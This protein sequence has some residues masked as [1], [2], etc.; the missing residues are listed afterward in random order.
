MQGKLKEK[1]FQFKIDSIHVVG[2]FILRSIAKPKTNVD[3]CITMPK[4]MFQ[5][6]FEKTY[7]QKRASF[8][9]HLSEL[10]KSTEMFSNF[11]IVPFRG[12]HLKPIIVIQPQK[13]SKS[14]SKFTK[15]DFKI[16]IL[17]MLPKEVIKKNLNDSILED[18]YFKDHLV[19]IHEYMKDYPSFVEASILLKV[20]L[21]QRFMNEGYNTINGFLL[22]YLMAYLLKTRILNKHMSSFQMIR[23]TFYWISNLDITKGLFFNEPKPTDGK[24]MFLDKNEFNVFHRITPNSWKEFQME[25][26][27]S[28]NHLEEEKK[29]NSIDYLFILKQNFYQKYDLHFQLDLKNC[30]FQNKAN[31]CEKITLYNRI[32]EI[33]SEALKDRS[34]AVGIKYPIQDKVIV[35]IKLTSNWRNAVI[36]GPSPVEKEKKQEFEN[37]WGD[38]TQMRRFK[39]S[40]ILLTTVWEYHQQNPVKMIH[41]IVSYILNKHLNIDTKLIGEDFHNLLHIPAE[42]REEY[43]KLLEQAI[44]KIKK[45]LFEVN[46]NLKIKEVLPVSEEFRNTSVSPILLNSNIISNFKPNSK[47]LITNTN[48]IIPLKLIIEFY[49]DSRWPENL[50]AIDKVKQLQ[51]IDIAEKIKL[52]AYPNKNWIDIYCYGFVFR[53]VIRLPLENSLFMSSGLVLN[54]K[55]NEIN[56]EQFKLPIHTRAIS[57]FSSR[58]L[59]YSEAVRLSKKWMRSHLFTNYIHE[60]LIELLVA[61]SFN[62]HQPSTPLIGFFQ[63]ISLLA[64]HDWKNTPIYVNLNDSK[65]K[66]ITNEQQGLFVLESYNDTNTPIWCKKDDPNEM[67]WD[68]MVAYA[69]E[70]EELLNDYFENQKTKCDLFFKTS[71]DYDV[72]IYLKKEFKFDKPIIGFDPIHHYFQNL[73][74]RF[75]KFGFFFRSFDEHFISIVWNPLK[76]E[77]TPFQIIK[78]S[79]SMKPEKDQNVVPNLDEILND[80]EEMGEGLIEKIQKK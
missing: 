79:W 39:D 8:L 74:D 73:R 11:E 23:N 10:F 24:I 78:N 28:L 1:S 55:V 52:K 22:S 42:D 26:K 14:D 77:S 80:V 68:R 29:T 51:Y 44:H 40:S 2:S 70:T 66:I 34:T 37:F 76:F 49:H 50:E 45:E 47:N 72:I 31:E 16:R 35:G 5:E 41:N 25:V 18:V 63:F 20:W 9:I 62:I 30:K 54:K 17:P 33:L 53:V 61:Y 58:N 65:D 69:K 48:N 19:D 75:E 36:K 13:D 46:S 57:V 38:K 43:E 12:D 71:K 32:I 59:A 21:T 64:N 4:E 60:E 15:T 3:I 27:S 56:R 67:I 6:G 7:F